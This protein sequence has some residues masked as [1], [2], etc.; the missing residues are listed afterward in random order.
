MRGVSCSPVGSER[1]APVGKAPRD[2][3]SANKSFI[4]VGLCLVTRSRKD[5]NVHLLPRGDLSATLGPSKSTKAKHDP[6]AR[7]RFY[8]ALLDE[9]IVESRAALARHLGVSRA[10]VTQVL[11][12]LSDSGGRRRSDD[13]LIGDA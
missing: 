12:R 5:R 7:A 1:L 11:K 4:E 2:D 8:Q 13:E 3:H 10:R 6:L 9:G